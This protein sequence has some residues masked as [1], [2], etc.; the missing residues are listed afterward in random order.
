M[1]R[2]G[3]PHA[4]PL[5]GSPRPAGVGDKA[6]GDVVC[7]DLTRLPHNVRRCGH[8]LRAPN[9]TRNSWSLAAAIS[10]RISASRRARFEG[11]RD[12]AS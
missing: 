10:A 6:R 11:L 1:S 9:R 12:L 3:A 4:R 7:P 8:I 5:L 2:R